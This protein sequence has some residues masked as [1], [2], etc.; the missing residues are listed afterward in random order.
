MSTPINIIIDNKTVLDDV[1]S[2]GIQ[3][4]DSAFCLSA[5][6]TL[7]SKDFWPLCDPATNFGT[8]RIRVVIGAA[9]YE[10][11]AEE[12]D[13]TPNRNGVDFTVWGRSKQALLAAPYSQTINDTE[14][15]ENTHPWQS[16]NTTASAIVA[17][18]VS[19]YCPY[20]VTVDW[21]AGDFTVYKDSFSVSNQ[22]P[23]DVIAALANVIG[24]ELVA[25]VDGSLSIEAYSVEEG[26]SVESFNDF[27]D[28]VQMN[29][30]IGYPSGFNAVTVYGYD[31][32]AANAA[33]AYMSAERKKDAG[34]ADVIY[35]GVR[36]KV[37]VYYYHGQGLAPLSS[38]DT[39]GSSTGSESIT[40]DVTLI[41]GHGNQSKPDANGNTSVEGSEDM[42]FEV[43]SVTYTTMFRDFTV[44]GIGVPRGYDSC[45]KSILFYFSDKS[46]YCLYSFTAT[47][48][49]SFAQQLLDEFGNKDSDGSG[50]LSIEEADI[51]Q[52]AFDAYDTDGDGEITES[53]LQDTL[54]GEG[55]ICTSVVLEALAL[56]IAGTTIGG[57]KTSV[58]TNELICIRVYSKNKP[59]S[60]YA[61]DGGAGNY[62]HWSREEVTEEAVFRSGAASLNY[63]IDDTVRQP[64]FYFNK[65]FG[66]SSP[67]PSYENGSNALT[68]N[69]F[70]GDKKYAAVP[71]TVV[72]HSKYWQYAVNVPRVWLSTVF[73]V[74]ADIPG[75]DIKELELTV[76]DVTGPQTP[77]VESTPSTRDITITIKDYTSGTVVEGAEVL[78]DG[79]LVGCTDS[80]GE[81]S[82]SSVS[83]GDHT[84]KITKTGYQDSDQDDLANDTFTVSA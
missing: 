24:A 58:S 20:S 74:W 16:G 71:C 46:A 39:A 38:G 5:S 51:P 55:A 84:I 70:V 21:N 17:Y 25:H 72:Y 10:F 31:A 80:S 69:S 40:E 50:G 82:M 28:I 13:T 33:N 61:A 35:E 49:E 67:S 18:V 47:R 78:V 79:D 63:P 81:V 76:S 22:S 66:N 26:S 43:K 2:C 75:C 54:G 27:E 41:F 77:A 83:V 44:D 56:G 12:R 1:D 9:T 15:T 11:L 37:R 42:P 14:D 19:T 45:T 73:G 48:R 52:D 30:G 36:H 3:M 4:S 59:D 60:L 34:E 65:A 62:Q 29:E 32:S 23:I 53:E 7:K 64:L 8:L 6:L 68:V 57:A